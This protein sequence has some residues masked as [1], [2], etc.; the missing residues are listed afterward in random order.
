[1]N[2][3]GFI[4]AEPREELLPSNFNHLKV[5]SYTVHDFMG[6]TV[7]LKEKLFNYIL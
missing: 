6:H 1:M 3:S 5:L 4:M 2:P 7:I